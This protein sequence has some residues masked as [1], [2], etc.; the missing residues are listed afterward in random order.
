MFELID[1]L[2]DKICALYNHRLQALLQQQR[3]NGEAGD[4][5]D[6]GDQRSVLISRE[7]DNNHPVVRSRR[8][9]RRPDLRSPQPPRA[10]AVKD[11]RHLRRPPEGLVLDG[12]EHDGTLA[13]VGRHRNSSDLGS[14]TI[15]ARDSRGE[16]APFRRAFSPPLTTG[17]GEEWWSPRCLH[18]SGTAGGSPV[19]RGRLRQRRR[20][21]LDRTATISVMRRGPIPALS[22][23]IAD[24][25]RRQR[26]AGRCFS[27]RSAICRRWDK[28]RCCERLKSA[29]FTASEAPRRSSI[30]VRVIA[31]SN[32]ALE[33]RINSAGFRE[34]LFFRLAEY[35]I[36]VPPLR[37]ATR[38]ISAFLARRFLGQAR[39]SLGRPRMEIAGGARLLRSHDWP[40]NARELRSAHAPGRAVRDRR[41]VTVAQVLRRPDRTQGT[42]R[43]ADPVGAGGTELRGRVRDTVRRSRTRCGHRGARAGR[44][45]QGGSRASLGIDYK[46]FG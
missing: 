44:R 4:S 14:A 28:K 11:G 1:E 6:A 5:D 12:R 21:A 2:R 24:G 35:V 41:Y 19:C 17:A 27:M 8:P 30:D 10:A 34:D 38:R 16:C 46:T 32:E 37:A 43:T 13:A 20:Y 3:N 9:S 29:S 23:A 36:V 7:R 42:R 15:V 22:T 33:E 39:E 18:A 25:S 45:Q 26:R 31:A 40:G